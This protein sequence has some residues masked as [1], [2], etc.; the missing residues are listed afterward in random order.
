[1]IVSLLDVIFMIQHN[2]KMQR[3]LKFDVIFGD[4]DIQ[5]SSLCEALYVLLFLIESSTRNTQGGEKMNRVLSY[6]KV[7]GKGAQG[8]SKMLMKQAHTLTKFYKF[9][10]VEFVANMITDEYPP[11]KV[12]YRNKNRDADYNSALKDLHFFLSST[13]NNGPPC[14]QLDLRVLG[15]NMTFLKNAIWFDIEARLSF[16]DCDMSKVRDEIVY[17]SITLDKFGDEALHWR[18]SLLQWMLLPCAMAFHRRLGAES[19]ISRLNMETFMMI[20]DMI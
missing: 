8:I 7:F 9:E 2:K 3:K 12:Y 18:H 4:S 16:K 20:V 17:L 6:M 5:P 19:I 14:M 1:M 15:D 11:E 13:V 10:D